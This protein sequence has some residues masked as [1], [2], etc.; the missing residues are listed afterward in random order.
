[1]L[2]SPSFGDTYVWKGNAELKALNVSAGE[3]VALS[4]LSKWQWSGTYSANLSLR[5]P[6]AG[7]VNTNEGSDGLGGTLYWQYTCETRMA[8]TSTVTLNIDYDLGDGTLAGYRNGSGL[9]VYNVLGKF[10]GKSGT[11]NMNGHTIWSEDFQ[12]G[13]NAS[14]TLNMDAGSKLYTRGNFQLGYAASVTTTLNMHGSAK[15]DHSGASFQPG[16]VSAASQVVNI[17]LYGSSVDFDVVTM[18]LNNYTSGTV[19]VDALRQNFTFVLDAGGAGPITISGAGTTALEMGVDSRLILE[20]T[21]EPTASEIVL[22]NLSNATGGISGSNGGKFRNSAGVTLNEGDVIEASLVGDSSNKLYYKLSYVGGTGN[23]VALESYMGVSLRNAGDSGDYTTW[24][25]GTGKTCDTAYVM[26]TSNCVL[27]KNTGSA[28]MDVG[29]SATGTKWTLA[30]STGLDQCVLMGLFNG[31]SAP[32][33]G[34]FSTSYDLLSSSVAWAT[35][36]G[37]S[38]HFEG[39]ANGVNIAAGGSGKLYMLLKTPASLSSASKA[40]ETTTVTISCKPH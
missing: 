27:V 26:N 20:F 14:W 31:N 40:S 19:G 4:T 17:N 2:V 1:M 39:A 30:S 18:K 25:I 7:I 29:L 10:S 34:D 21:S 9:A 22:F 23:D 35:S 15:L 24:A 5:I 3:T 32:V 12:S 38:G 6:W 16:R 8:E 28:A 36:S 13:T 11:V 37:G 33:A